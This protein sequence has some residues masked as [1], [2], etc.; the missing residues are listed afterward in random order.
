[1]DTTANTL[2]SPTNII[3]QPNKQ[4]LN[5]VVDKNKYSKIDN[6]TNTTTSI[7]NTTNS[8]SSTSINKGMNHINYMEDDGFMET[9]E[10][11]CFP[12][13]KGKK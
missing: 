9:Q 7:T 12:I 4:I 6:A 13:R 8:I 10:C 5:K 2:L 1:M 11:N 3:F